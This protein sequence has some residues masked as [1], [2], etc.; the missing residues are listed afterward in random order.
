[1]SMEKI[2]CYDISGDLLGNLPRSAV[3]EQAKSQMV[4]PALGFTGKKLLQAE[5]REKIVELQHV[6]IPIISIGS[7]I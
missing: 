2:K 3:L 6:Y 7:H 5:A 4:H 1:M